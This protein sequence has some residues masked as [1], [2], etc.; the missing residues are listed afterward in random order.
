MISRRRREGFFSWC[1]LNASAGHLKIKRP[2]WKVTGRTQ[3]W[4]SLARFDKVQPLCKRDSI[5]LRA[6]SKN[7]FNNVTSEMSPL[8]N[9]VYAN[10]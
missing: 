10:C 5:S 3:P 1:K 8:A 9:Y 2:G 6:I 7:Y 4:P